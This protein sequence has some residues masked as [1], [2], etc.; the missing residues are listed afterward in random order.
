MT[1]IRSQLGN[2][3]FLTYV[4]AEKFKTDSLSVQFLTPLRRDTAAL[5]ALLPAVLDRGCNRYPDMEQLSAALDLLYGANVEHIVRKRGEQQLWGFVASC[6]DHAFLPGGESVLPALAEILGELIC[7]PVL[8]DG[9]L[10]ADYVVSEQNNLLDAIRSAVNDKRAFA[11]KRLLEEMCRDEAYGLSQLGELETVSAITPQSLTAYYRQAISTQQVELYYCGR[12]SL[13][14]VRSICGRI[15][16]DLPRSGGVAPC[17]APEVHPPRAKPQMIREKMDVTQ[18]KLGIGFSVS[19]QDRD[20]VYVMNAMFG[21]TSNSKLFLNVREKLSLCYY[22]SSTYHRSKNLITVSSGIEFENYQKALDEI[23]AQL[24]AMRQGDWEDWEW[25]GA[26]RSIANAYRSLQDSPGR[27]EDFYLGQIATGTDR[28]P[29]ELMDA[30]LAVTPERIR[31]AASS[32]TL[33]T[34]YFLTG[35]EAPNHD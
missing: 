13:E 23:L 29:R 11:G 20:A 12:A 2:N 21:G 30:A 14:E 1:K 6:V 26:M 32:V 5:T 3:I 31:A 9:L 35:K 18:G 8:E 4:P 7:C 27:M 25:N 17:T 28:S 19:S 33:D 16:K 24:D 15:L 10:K 34:V 22:A